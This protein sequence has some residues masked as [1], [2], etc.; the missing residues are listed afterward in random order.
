[1]AF[2]HSGFDAVVAAARS[3]DSDAFERLFRELQP[4]LLRFLRS[5]EERAADDLAAEVWLAVAAR[6]SRFEGNWADFRAWVFAIG[7][8][9][10]ADH[11]RTAVRRRTDPV[12]RAAFGDRRAEDDPEDETVDKISGQEAASLIASALPGDQ[13]EVVL[14][15]VLADLDVD[16]VAAILQRTP[17]WVRVTQHRAVGNLA[18]RL[19]PKIVVIR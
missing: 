6:I 13:A 1:M 10:L 5:M 18:K 19:G 14:L 7:R 17:N 15:R 9:R 3:G 2:D 8:K 16:Q 12:D 4:R 11:R